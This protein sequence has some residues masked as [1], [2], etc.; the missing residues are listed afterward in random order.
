MVGVA[1]LVERCVVVADAA[2]SSPVTH[3]TYYCLGN[4]CLRRFLGSRLFEQQQRTARSCSGLPSRPSCTQEDQFQALVSDPR[5]RA[6]TRDRDEYRGPG[7][8]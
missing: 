7:G 5:Q 2:G 1:Q 3:P 8:R 4:F 6:P